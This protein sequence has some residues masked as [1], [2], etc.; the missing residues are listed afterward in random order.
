VEG[1]VVAAAITFMTPMTA[2]APLAL[3]G[4]KAI[5]QE[6]AYGDVERRRDDLEALI[7]RALDS[8]DYREGAAA[9]LE[10]RPPRFTGR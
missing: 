9:F 5:L 3:A 2:N 4:T 1:D 8:A 7:R 10:K 6:L